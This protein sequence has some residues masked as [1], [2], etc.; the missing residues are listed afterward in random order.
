MQVARRPD[1]AQYCF[2]HGYVV[3]IPFIRGQRYKILPGEKRNLTI[4]YICLT[5]GGGFAVICGPFLY[6]RGL[7]RRDSFR[8]RPKRDQKP[9]FSPYHTAAIIPQSRRKRDQ[10]S[11]PFGLLSE[12]YFLPKNPRGYRLGYRQGFSIFIMEKRNHVFGYMFG[13]SFH[14]QKT[15]L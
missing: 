3:L 4:V 5:T 13:Y 10:I 15:G 8:F 14:I 12:A 2:F 1:P 7:R 11:P 6:I 9:D